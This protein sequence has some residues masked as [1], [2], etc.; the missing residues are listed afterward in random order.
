[1]IYEPTIRN[2]GIPDGKFL[3]KR[4][5]KN[6]QNNSEFFVPTDLVVGKDITINGYSFNILE[7]DDYT[8]KWYASNI[9]AW[10]GNKY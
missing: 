3:E 9:V 5:Y 2:S 6:V 10:E 1:M 8:K 7:C 4:R